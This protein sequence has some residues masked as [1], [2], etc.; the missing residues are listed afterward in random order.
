MWSAVSGGIGQSLQ[1]PEF[2]PSNKRSLQSVVWPIDADVSGEPGQRRHERRL[3][4][5]LPDWRSQIYPI[6]IEAA[7]LTQVAASAHIRD[8]RPSKGTVM[9][10]HP[11]WLSVRNSVIGFMIL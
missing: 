6:R 7:V 2:R 10:K 9:R 1:L 8:S 5:S 11:V 3:Q 4:S